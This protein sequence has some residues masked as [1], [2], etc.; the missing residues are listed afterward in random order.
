MFFQT[1]PQPTIAAQPALQPVPP[2]TAAIKPRAETPSKASGTR[3]L[4]TI[5]PSS[6][7]ASTAPTL[8]RPAS[9]MS[10]QTFAGGVVTNAQTGNPRPA[11]RPRKLNG[12]HKINSDQWHSQ[13]CKASKLFYSR[14]SNNSNNNNSSIFSSNSNN[15]IN[16]CMP[17][18]SNSLLNI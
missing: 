5:L 17:Y 7:G 18:L 13:S 9:S 14:Y 3:P 10:N 6:S 4:S 16:N 12:L 1:A 11:V 15:R 8:I 2:L